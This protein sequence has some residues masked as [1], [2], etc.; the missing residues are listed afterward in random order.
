M[1]KAEGTSL[2]NTKS[3]VNHLNL[4]ITVTYRIA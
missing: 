2:P 1:E 4:I 3:E